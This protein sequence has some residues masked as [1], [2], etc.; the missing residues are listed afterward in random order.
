LPRANFNPN[1]VIGLLRPEWSG[2]KPV[3]CLGEVLQSKENQAVW[4]FLHSI[5]MVKLKTARIGYF[6]VISAGN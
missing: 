2:V 5:A 6:E 3:R 1:Y 4:R